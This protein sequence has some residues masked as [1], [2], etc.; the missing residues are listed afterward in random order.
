MLRLIRFFTFITLALA[1][2]VILYATARPAQ[3]DVPGMSETFSIST[4]DGLSLTLSEDGQVVALAVDGDPLPIDPAPALWVRDMSAAGQ[5]SEP[6]L[7]ANPGL[8][9]GETDWQIGYQVGTDIVFTDTVSHSGDWSLQLHGFQTE[10]L[11]R[12]T[13]AADPVDVTPGQRYRLSA[14]LLSGRGYVRAMAGTPPRC[15]DQVWRGLAWP[16]GVYLSWLDGD[17]EPIGDMVMVA[18][19]HWEAYSWRKVSGE[20]R[21]P[22]DAAQMELTIGGRLQDEYLWVDDLSIVASPEV[23]Q[24]VTGVVV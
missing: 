21:A 3:A 7:L 17:G 15:Q 20:V 2:S 18:P 24:P 11:G 4:D 23:E 5:V 10:N 14:Y 8:E 6:N 19:L 13:V 9:D 22:P 12:A 1:L 16:N